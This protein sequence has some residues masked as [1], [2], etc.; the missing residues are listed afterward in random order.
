MRNT[1]F[2]AFLLECESNPQ[3]RRKHLKELLPNPMQRVTKYP[4]LIQQV[5]CYQVLPYCVTMYYH[6]LP[7]VTMC[8]HDVLPC[9][10][11]CCYHVLPCVI[12][13]YH[14]LPRC[15][16]MCYHVFPQQYVSIINYCGWPVYLLRSVYFIFSVVQILICILQLNLFL[17]LRSVQR[18][19]THS[20][21]SFSLKLNSIFSDTQIHEN[22]HRR[23]QS[24]D[25]MFRKDQRHLLKVI[26][27]LLH[28][29]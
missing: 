29:K 7:C 26:I 23:T 18:F 2:A 11:M 4:L 3:C 25:R 9:V 16:I 13:C 19:S 1:D 6:V 12:M 22:W 5:L 10:T 21:L 17:K 8:Y 27:C 28:V 14:V 24:N 20:T 15:V